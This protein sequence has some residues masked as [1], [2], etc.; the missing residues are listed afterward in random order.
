MSNDT[1]AALGY[2]F[3]VISI[4][5]IAWSIIVFVAF[6]PSDADRKARQQLEIR[7]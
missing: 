5:L 6:V 2:L 4:L 1:D 3:W 7:K